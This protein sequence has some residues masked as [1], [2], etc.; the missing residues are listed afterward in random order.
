[1][2]THTP[3]ADTFD[4]PTR[5][6]VQ[7]LRQA[8]ES[9][10]DHVQIVWQAIDEV[11]EVIGQTVG[12]D[13]AEF[14]HVEPPQDLPLGRYRPFA[15]YEPFAEWR[16]EQD[17]APSDQPTRDSENEAGT[18]LSADVFEHVQSAVA[19]RLRESHAEGVDSLADT[20][21]HDDQSGIPVNGAPAHQRSLWDASRGEPPEASTTD[22][23]A[24]KAVTSQKEAEPAATVPEP[25]REAAPVVEQTQPKY[26]APLGGA[27]LIALMQRHK[28]TIGE[29]AKRTSFTQTRIREVRETGLQDRNAVRDWLQAILGR[30][31]GPIGARP[32]VEAY[33][34]DDWIAFRHRVADDEVDAAGIKGEFQRMKDGRQQFIEQLLKTKSADQLRLMAMQ[35]GSFDASRNTKKDNAESIYRTHLSAFTLGESVRYS[36][37]E[38]TYTE[39]L[40]RMVM[41]ITNEA[42]AAQ[43]E[44][45]QRDRA[46][47]EKALTNPETL[48]EF[49]TFNR[50]RG[51]DELSDEQF[52]LWDKLHADRVRDD[53]RSRKQPDTV[54]QF[55]SAEIAGTE[56]RIIDGFHEREQVP[57]YIVQLTSRVE[58]S[59]FNELKVK[60]SQLGGWWSSFKKDSAGFQFR[61][62]ESAE[63]FAGLTEGDADRSAERAARKLRKMDNASDRLNAVAA[64]L[65][66]KAAEVLAADDAKLKNTARRADMAT[67]MRAQA[68][69]DQADA[70]TLRSIAAALAAGEATYL[71]GVWN[72][73]QVRTLE[74]ILRRAR[75]ERIQQRLTEEGIDRA[76]HRWSQRYEELENEPLTPAD[77]RFAVFPKPYLYYGHLQQ[78]FARLA[79]TPGVKQATA[80]M[81]K[82]VDRR[83]K[84]QEF[85]EFVNDY[86]IELLEDFLGRA[87]A[88]GVKIWWFDHCLDDY[89]RL[90]S[91]HIEDAHELRMALRELVPHL[92]AV[93]GDNPITKAEDEL[94]GKDLPGFFPTPR[95]LID[96]MLDDAQIEPTHTVLEPSCGKGDIVDGIRRRCPDASIVA[97]ERNL[98]LQGVLSAKGYGDIVTYGDF[99]EYQEACDRVVMNP[100]FE[101]GQDIEHVR[102]AFDLLAPGGRLVAIM[103]E[104]PFFRSDAKSS[105]FREWLSTIDSEYDTSLPDDTFKGVDA[106]RQ[107]GVKTRYVILNK[108]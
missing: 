41:A 57:L 35:S 40:E 24:A 85:V 49:A 48:L 37:M 66:E 1:M 39:A 86:Q 88:A 64:S 12:H 11:R 15:G 91:A 94:R 53:R 70:S 14:W 104:G 71:D 98:T 108:P 5:E 26:F 68:Y 33:T 61:S 96:R 2:S 76:R 80:K 21:R 42:I 55:Q 19:A 36:P 75:R 73:A 23:A 58:R 100:P 32:A 59:T 3:S 51:I 101:Q 65:N 81:R 17:D 60:A 31:P 79:N 29:L 62:R 90:T 102:H 93:A 95:P 74:T 4:L 38:E 7:E 6:D 28:V 52:A 50:E 83:P 72:A 99:L 10:R 43:R 77:A 20:H 18:E 63:K 46:A 97:V 105:T 89:K 9:L 44:K 87:R 107:T 16:A 27:E 103:S 84:D 13:A 34:L 8:I 56:F 45:R 30:D 67:S 82:L 54:E 106:F 69:A 78:A 92:A 25:A 22:G 47:R